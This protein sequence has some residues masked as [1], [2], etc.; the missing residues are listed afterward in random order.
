MPSSCVVP[1]CGGLGG[2]RFPKD[3]ELNTKWRIAVKKQVSTP[4][5]EEL[6]KPS[7]SSRVCHSHFK[8]ED[9]K[10]SIAASYS[11]NPKVPRIRHLNEGVIPSIF[12][13]ST[14]SASPSADGASSLTEE[15]AAV[16]STSKATLAEETAAVPQATSF[17]EIGCEEEDVLVELVQHDTPAD[18]G[19]PVDVAIQA[20]TD[21][22]EREAQTTQTGE[23][24]RSFSIQ[25]I[26]D[27]PEAVKFYTSFVS[28]KHFCYVLNSLGPSAYHLD[29]KSRSLTTEDEFFLFLMKLRLNHEDQDMAYRFNISQTVVSSVFYTWLQFVYYQLQELVKFIPKEVIDQ[30]MPKDFKAKYPSTRVILDATEVM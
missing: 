8:P 2:Y 5:S 22:V 30:H 29:Y 19:E 1:G 11:V 13:W 18:R 20:Q 7:D 16:P 4:G 6:W 10:E 25:D 14:E 3:P 26:K 15:S 12:P 28:Y 24:R 17:I 23:I 9:F 27:D 21:S